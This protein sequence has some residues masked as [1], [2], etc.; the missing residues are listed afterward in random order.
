M[1]GIYFYSG[2]LSKFDIREFQKLEPRGPD[3]SRLEIIDGMIFGFHRLAINDTSPLGMQPFVTESSILICNGEIYNYKELSKEFKDVLVSS[4][5]CEVIPHMIVKYGI[6]KTL[7]MINGEFAF[8]Y[9]DRYKKRLYV[10][11][12]HL[13]IRP[14]FYMITSEESVYISSEIK[15]FPLNK[16]SICRPFR[17]SPGS[18][19][20]LVRETN[21]GHLGNVVMKKTFLKTEKYYE[22]PA[23]EQLY[24]ESNYDFYLKKIKDSL[25][26]A[27]KSRLDCVESSEMIGF[28]LSGGL[29][30]SLVVAIARHILGESAIIKTFSI[31]LKDSPDLEAARKVSEFLNTEH[32]ECLTTIE[33]MLE[34]ID[35]VI[36]TIESFDVTT[37][38]A[39]TPNYHL[40]H[41]IKSSNPDIKVVLSGEC[42]DEI[43][44]Y[45]YLKLAPNQDE[46]DKETRKLLTNISKFDVTRA[47]RCIS[48]AGLECRVPFMDKNFINTI[49]EMPVE[50]KYQPQ[51]IEKKAFRDAFIGFLPQD[52][53]FRPKDAFS[54]AVGLNWVDHLINKFESYKFKNNFAFAVPQPKTK[55]AI[56]YRQVFTN[57]YSMM[58]DYLYPEYW[59]PNPN[60]IPKLE[61]PSARFINIHTQHKN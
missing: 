21:R 31:G 19:G 47:D 39:S 15:A 18:Y 56:Y 54:D 16:D 3:A 7:E 49:M 61:D 28:C 22:L 4:S 14:L 35:S 27:V 40:A 26:T 25:I 30:S 13:G 24:T 11:N 8:I 2:D 33:E 37:I 46:F 53:L 5:D 29:D 10:A 17:L 42:S 41:F 58:A 45:K 59:M 9:Y 23:S 38:R 60:W 32:Y 50:I 44:G 55:E 6:A 57:R 52:I 1:C 43:C 48:S 51:E 12:D 20:E 34:T 36:E